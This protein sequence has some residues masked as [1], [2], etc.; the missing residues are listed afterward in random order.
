M[1]CNQGQEADDDVA[2]G[3][4]QIMLTCKCLLDFNP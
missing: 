1:I 3:T 2:G 4:I